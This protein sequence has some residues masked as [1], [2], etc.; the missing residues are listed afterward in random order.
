MTATRGPTPQTVRP[1]EYW[2]DHHPIGLCGL[3]A[4]TMMVSDIDVGSCFIQ[5]FLNGEMVYE[6]ARPAIAGRAA[7][8]QVSDAVVELLMPTG[9]GWLRR[10]FDRIGQ[11]MLSIV[12][13]VRDLRQARRYFE[14]RDVELIAG[15]GPDRFAVAPSANRGALFEFAEQGRCDANLL[16]PAGEVMDPPSRIRLRSAP[17]A[18]SPFEPWPARFHAPS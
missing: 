10:E 8:L 11:G 12:F 13:R 5:S 17:C 6:E 16:A 3:K 18:S 9:D 4:Y 2:R 15:A 7:G 14:E 1:V